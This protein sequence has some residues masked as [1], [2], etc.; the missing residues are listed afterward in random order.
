MRCLKAHSLKHQLAFLFLILA[1]NRD[2]LSSIPRIEFAGHMAHIR[3]YSSNVSPKNIAKWKLYHG[4]Q[5]Q[6]RWIPP[7]LEELEMYGCGQL[8][9]T[10]RWPRTLTSIEIVHHISAHRLNL[11]KGLESL[12]YAYVTSPWRIY[13]PKFEKLCSSLSQFPEFHSFVPLAELSELVNC[14]IFASWLLVLILPQ[15]LK[16][17]DLQSNPI[18]SLTNIEF[19]ALL[20]ELDIGNC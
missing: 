4:S 9:D 1:A 15:S 13:P 6:R 3:K 16:I 12:V 17:L 8:S 19:P 7:N 2:F 20:E 18:R 11:P 14:G 5:L 10:Q